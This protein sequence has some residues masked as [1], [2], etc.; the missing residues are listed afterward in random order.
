MLY[1]NLLYKYNALQYGLRTVLGGCS[2]LGK[3]SPDL[4]NTSAPGVV[5]PLSDVLATP[6]NLS[7]SDFILIVWLVLRKYKKQPLSSYSNFRVD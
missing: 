5:C 6:L 1:A 3:H 4:P 2:I 7:C